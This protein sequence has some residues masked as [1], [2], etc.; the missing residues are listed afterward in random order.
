MMRSRYIDEESFEEW[1][2]RNRN[3]KAPDDQHGM[4]KPL[5]SFIIPNKKC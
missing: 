3:S 1:V 5:D 2:V 4:V